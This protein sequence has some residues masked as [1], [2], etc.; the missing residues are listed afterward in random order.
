MVPFLV[1]LSFPP[2]LTC[3]VFEI[4]LAKSSWPAVSA[5]QK[6]ILVLK[7]KSWVNLWMLLQLC[8]KTV[9]DCKKPSWRVGFFMF[10]LNI[11]HLFSVF[12]PSEHRYIGQPHRQKARFATTKT[13]SES[14]P[15]ASA[16]REKNPTDPFKD[17]PSK[18]VSC[19][20]VRPKT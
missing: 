20:L 2:R 15:G 6:N 9:C 1:A 13:W 7:L 12:L 8:W 11:S 4:C 16:H 14:V 18:C 17:T 19:A 5:K 10:F 3:V